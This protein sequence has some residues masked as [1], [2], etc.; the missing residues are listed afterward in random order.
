MKI[1]KDE[2]WRRLQFDASEIHDLNRNR[3]I[4]VFSGGMDSTIALW[5]AMDRYKEL[6]VLSVE[7]NQPHRE[8]LECAKRIANLAGVKQRI[9]PIG[10]PND[11]WGIQNYL[12]RGQ[13]GLMTAIAALDISHEGADI[14][15]GILRTDTYPDCERTYLDELARI[16]PHTLDTGKIGI[17]TPLRALEDKKAAA[18][19]GFL[20]GAPID[21]SWSC[22]KPIQGRPCLKCDPCIARLEVW[23]EMEDNFGI[24]PREFHAWQHVLGSPFHPEVR[25]PSYEISVLTKAFLD[26]DGM[27]AGQ[28]GWRYVGPDGKCRIAT[29]IRKNEANTDSGEIINQVSVHGFFEDNYRWEYVVCQDGAVAY[30]DK[31]PDIEEIER[32]LTRELV[33][34]M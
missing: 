4:V 29:L 22:R 5:W 3:A 24:T 20:I 1:S 13:A 34:R 7:Y 6:E 33:S 16:L 17:A 9:I 12:T 32:V 15:H 27:R 10:I 31:L 19:Y 14:V 2:L 18:V 26:M 21:L 25:E 23:K 8:E 28:P 30:T 11:F